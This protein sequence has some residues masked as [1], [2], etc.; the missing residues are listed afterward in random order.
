MSLL[1]DTTLAATETVYR[2]IYEPRM[3]LLRALTRLHMPMPRA[4]QTAAEYLLNLDI[5]RAFEAEELD[6][7]RL[8]ALLEDSR[9]AH[10]T[11]DAMA[12]QPP[13]RQ[14]LTR[15]ATRLA[16]TPSNLALLQTLADAVALVRTLPFDVDLWK[17]Q[18]VFY[19]LCHTVYPTFRHSADQGDAP[20][21]LWVHHFRALGDLLSVW[22][23][24]LHTS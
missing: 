4:L 2:Q 22:V 21:R 6:L 24:S 17:V 9:T 5:Q 8:S 20:A 18:N 13:I 10:L 16:A 12:L 1:L 3:P 11:L 15:L 7:G 14:G 19:L 23:E